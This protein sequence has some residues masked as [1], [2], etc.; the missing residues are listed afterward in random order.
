VRLVIGWSH[1][2]NAHFHGRVSAQD[3]GALMVDD[4]KFY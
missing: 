2:K 3:G 1:M 4:D